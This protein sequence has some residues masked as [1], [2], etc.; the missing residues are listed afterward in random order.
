M[1]FEILARDAD[2]EFAMINATIVCAHQ[3]GAGA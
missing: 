1:V 2:S 3:H